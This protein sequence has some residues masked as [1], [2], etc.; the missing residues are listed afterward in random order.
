[1]LF[2]R[3]LVFWIGLATSTILITPFMPL[4]FPFPY[5]I[6][7]R[8]A[9]QWTRFNMFWLK[10]CC[11]LSY[12]VH[13][14]K[15]IPTTPCII[16]SKHQSAWE[17]MALQCFFPPQVWVMK[18]EILWIPFFGWAIAAM[19]PIAIDRSSGRRAVKQ[20]IDQGRQRLEDGR[21]IVIFPEGTRVPP[22]LKGRYGL[23]GGVLAAETCYPVIPVAHNAGEFWRRNAFIKYPG[24]IDVV[25]GEAID[26]HGL[27]AAEIMQKT[28]QW[29]E[30]EMEKISITPYTGDVH[31][32]HQK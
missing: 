26:T 25:I 19:E 30:G 4:I 8:F 20:I 5:S 21:W 12:R 14:T 9:H 15:N 31:K 17:T 32:R 1:M 10:F 11:G 13:G 6:R 3:S 22:G 7:Y 23:G 2:L 28:E 27:D 29:I 24:M 18:R 16:M